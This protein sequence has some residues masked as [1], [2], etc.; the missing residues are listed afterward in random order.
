MKQLEQ[1]Y[2]SAVLVLNSHDQ[3]KAVEEA[4]V[5]LDATIGQHFKHYELILVQNATVQFDLA[6]VEVPYILVDLFTKQNQQAA[7][8]AGVDMAIGDYILEIPEIVEGMDYSYL[9]QMYQKSQENNDFVFLAPA[10]TSFLS[11]VYY[12]ILSRHFKHLQEKNMTSALMTLSSRRGQNRIAELGSRVV[13]RNL[14][15]L[16]SGLRTETISSAIAYRNHRSFSE[17]IIFSLDTLLYYT[18]IIMVFL[19]R[20]AYVF[21]TI[22]LIGLVYSLILRF[23]RDIVEGWASLFVL[24]SFGFSGVFFILS[25]VVRYLYHILRNTNR[26]QDYIYRDVIRHK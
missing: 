3:Q 2:L 13:N 21:F 11:K 25:I 7:L 9:I 12:R 19:Q 6:A 26:S 10:E 17:N 18:N 22:F 8:A 1:N 23:T 16:L 15:Y 20:I 4:I 5:N 14:S 24:S